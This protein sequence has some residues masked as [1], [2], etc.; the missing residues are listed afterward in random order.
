MTSYAKNNHKSYWVQKFSPEKVLD[1]D[2]SEYHVVC[3]K[4]N[5]VDQI[6]SNLS[7]YKSKP[8]FSDLVKAVLSYLRQEKYIDALA[9]KYN[10]TTIN[11]ENFKLDRVEILKQVFQDI[12]E[13]IGDYDRSISFKKNSSFSNKKRSAYLNKQQKKQILLL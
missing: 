6:R 9:Q 1:Y 12:R 5:V 7:R 2:L 3:I 13:T 4:R 10:A 11:Y 8:T